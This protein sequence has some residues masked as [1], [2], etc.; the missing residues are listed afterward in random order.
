[1]KLYSFSVPAKED[2]HSCSK[3]V[4]NRQTKLEEGA[5]T[6]LKHKLLKN[7]EGEEQYRDEPVES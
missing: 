2:S 3:I 4:F 7:N 1:M 5:W 6:Y